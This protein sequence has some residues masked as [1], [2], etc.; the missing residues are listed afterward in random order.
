MRARQD[1]PELSGDRSFDPLN[2]FSELHLG[3]VGTLRSHGKSEE[4]RSAT[5]WKLYIRD[6]LF[7][8]KTEAS[9]ISV[10]Q[11]SSSE[12]MDQGLTIASPSYHL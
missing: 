12:Q 7:G 10:R 4:P 3:C 2:T 8:A 9:I 11:T 5:T 6:G 1:L